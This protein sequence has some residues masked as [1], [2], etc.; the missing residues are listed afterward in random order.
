MSK[1]KQAT[2][3]SKP[4]QT[5]TQ[6]GKKENLLHIFKLLWKSQLRKTYVHSITL[7]ISNFFENITK[8]LLKFCMC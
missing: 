4:K 8:T 5:Q 1:I 2:F 7:Y 3:S 6:K